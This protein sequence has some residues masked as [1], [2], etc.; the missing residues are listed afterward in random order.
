MTMLHLLHVNQGRGHSSSNWLLVKVHLWLENR[1]I[2]T[3]CGVRLFHGATDVL[4]PVNQDPHVA[5][6]YTHACILVHKMKLS[7][8]APVL[9]PPPP[10]PSRRDFQ[11]LE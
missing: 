7:R 9:K 6:V 3:V 10:K 8:A 11:H 4:A 2:G 5:A 1:G